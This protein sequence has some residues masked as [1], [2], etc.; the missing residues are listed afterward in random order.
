MEFKEVFPIWEKLKKEEQILLEKNISR[1][2]I[3]KN[4][5]L[6]RGFDDC[7]GLVV[8]ISGSATTRSIAPLSFSSTRCVA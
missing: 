1:H 6:H 8:V 4:E 3:K 7:I 5:I 2:N